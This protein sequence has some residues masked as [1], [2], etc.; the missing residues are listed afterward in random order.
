MSASALLVACAGND[1]PVAQLPEI[2]TNNPL[3]A[4]WETPHATPPFDKI[5]ISDYEPAFETAIA[6]SRAE[7]DAIVNNPAK[8]SFNNTILAL[9]KQGEL[10]DRISSVFFNMLQCNTS[11]ELQDI[12][13]R[14][15]PKLTELS[16]D[17]SLN[18]E[19]FKRIKEVNENPGL[20]LTKEDKKLLENTYKSF[21]RSGA[22]LADAEK[23]LYRQYSS[24]LSQL[25]LQFGQNSLAANNAY[26]LNITKASQVAELPDFVK[27]GLAMDAKARGQ[28]GWTVT[29]KAPS[30]GPFM[31]YSSQRDLKEKLY[32]ARSSCAI[33]GKFDNTENIRKITA[34]RL[35]I[36][37]LLGYE[38]YA[39]YVLDNRMAEKTAIVNSFLAELLS[40][41][42]E[43]A[44]K[45][46][47]TINAYA[48]SLG[49]K[50]DIQPWDFSYYSEKYKNEKYAVSDEAVKPYLELEN[51]KQAVFMLAN[52]LYGL[53]FKP[54]EGVAKYHEDVAVYEV[55]EANGNHLSILYLDFFPRDSK[56]A[57]AWMTE[58]R[59]AEGDIR[60]LVSLVMNFTKPTET[61]PSLITFDE[62]TT[63]LHEFGHACHGML[64]KGKHGSFNGTNVF[65]DFVDLPSQILENWAYEKEYLD[66]WAKHYQT[67]ETMPAELIEKIIAAKNYLA[68]YANVRQVSFGMTD[69]AWH[70][71]T[72]P[73]EGDVVEFEQ[74]AMAVAQ[75]LPI[76]E[77]T[78]LSPTFGH[79]FSGGYA[80]GYYG[81]KWAE[82]LA[83]DGYS[84]FTENGIFDKA[85]A[86]KFR[87]LLESGGKEHPMD[88]YVAFRG[89][90]P[91]TKALIDQMG[92]G[93]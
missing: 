42:K 15:Q 93:K 29:L 86:S 26:S 88:L 83:A 85:T 16:N 71:L 47:Q 87:T 30:Y 91:Q 74:K 27:E 63:F 4:E 60:P 69:M 40:Q 46:Y 43:Y 19:L 64:A 35:K 76:V 28:K 2:D 55:S 8:P 58:F 33:G 81:Y 80:A 56:R 9:E 23:E 79:L 92:L 44:D 52:K 62:F 37:N 31:T 82:V 48:H 59:G 50:G 10:L 77:G 12:A 57:G 11:D 18:P 66:L 51:V 53:E 70:T 7:V 3:L 22:N 89:H 34:L 17:V 65:R 14:I 61:T 25:T 45:D 67:G 73:Y 54:A 49:F 6:V 5:S 38:C 41:T 21:V 68:A 1:M 78:A 72:A 24:E 75:V 20:F 13:M 90:K 36:A 39:D 84:L 32:K